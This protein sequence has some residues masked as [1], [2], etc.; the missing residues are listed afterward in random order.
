MV[1]KSI[2]TSADVLNLVV[3][4][5]TDMARQSRC[6][7]YMPKPIYNTSLSKKLCGIKE[8]F[9]KKVR[10]KLLPFANYPS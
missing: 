5:F 4:Q 8:K 7:R 6:L 1:N 10:P 2:T 3:I 9:G